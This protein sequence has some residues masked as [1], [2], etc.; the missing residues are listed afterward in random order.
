MAVEEGRTERLESARHDARPPGGEAEAASCEPLVRALSQPP[1]FALEQ[2]R[3]GA[4]ADLASPLPSWLTARLVK[5]IAWGRSA[6]GGTVHIEVG[7]GELEGATLT[8][9]CRAGCLSVTVEAPPGVDGRVWE[10]RIG[11]ALSA[12]GVSV[13]TIEVR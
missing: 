10:G 9:D 1:V 6:T 12:R 11:R 7:E 8:I 3:E 2:P 5:R 13:D 4:P